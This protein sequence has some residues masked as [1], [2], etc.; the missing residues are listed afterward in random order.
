MTE[1]TRISMTAPSERLEREKRRSLRAE[2][3]VP[4][5]VRW[6]TTNGSDREEP[7]KT[8]IINA[9]GCL[10]LM[11]T[12]LAERTEVELVNR[13]TGVVRRGQVVWCGAIEP[14]GRTQIGIELELP[15]LK[16]W[17]DQYAEY[18]MWASLAAGRSGNQGFGPGG[19]RH[20]H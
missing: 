13:N 14:D 3:K 20:G 16:F 18:L 6:R 2:L 1:L 17:G 4:L 8:K 12:P 11:K 10:A 7:A 15:D 5:L 9:H 19:N